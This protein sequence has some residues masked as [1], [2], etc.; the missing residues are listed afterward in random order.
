MKL[1]LNKIYPIDKY[2][3]TVD[4]NAKF[5]E[6][7]KHGLKLYIPCNQDEATIELIFNEKG[8]FLYEKPLMFDKTYYR[9]LYTN[10]YDS[11]VSFHQNAIKRNKQMSIFDFM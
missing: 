11:L 1:K 9:I 8:K 3:L 6:E 2:G 5:M 4:R 10:H 7:S